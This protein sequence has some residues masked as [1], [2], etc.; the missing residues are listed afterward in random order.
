M[1]LKSLTAFSAFRLKGFWFV[2]VGTAKPE[3]S[4]MDFD[5]V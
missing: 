3:S 2:R 5:Q 4:S 1:R